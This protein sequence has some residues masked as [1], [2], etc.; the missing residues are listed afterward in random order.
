MMHGAVGWAFLPVAL[1]VLVTALAPA[2]AHAAAAAATA[3]GWRHVV[4]CEESLESCYDERGHWVVRRRGALL[5]VRARQGRIHSFRDHPRPGYEDHLGHAL[6]GH[7]VQANA[8]YVHTEMHEGFRGDLINLDTGAIVEA[9]GAVVSPDGRTMA[10]LY[11]DDMGCNVSVR[12]LDWRAAQG[13]A[14]ADDLLAGSWSCSLPQL[15]LRDLEWS[16]NARVKVQHGGPQEF[17]LRRLHG[18]NWTSNLPCER[19]Q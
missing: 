1:M 13:S 7:V 5:Q 14:I 6:R 4:R 17:V 15:S 16:G 18:G 12:S 8:V 2:A 19:R 11:C 10:L 3:A 9:S